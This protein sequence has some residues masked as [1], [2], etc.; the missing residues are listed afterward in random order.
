MLRTDPCRAWSLRHWTDPDGTGR[1]DIRGPVDATA[2]VLARLAP[3]ERELFDQARHDQR[4]ERSDVLAFDALIALADTAPAGGH[5]N[6][7]TTIVVRIDHGALMRGHTEPGEVSELADG[8]PIPVAVVSRMLDDAFVKAV[9]VDGTDVRAVS[10]LGRTIPAR[11][12]TAV[13]ELYPECC[14][15]GCNVTHNLEIDHN[16]PVE[17]GGPTALWN[18]GRLCPHHHWYKH[19]HDRRL[20]GDGTHKHFVDAAPRPPPERGRPPKPVAD[21]RSGGEDRS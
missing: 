12:R 13:E 17:H 21:A 9:V 15:E 8:G 7:E 1:I 14:V 18:L 4:R 3:Y 16:Q 11:L 6:P 5:A 10:H 19:H 2:R 20:A